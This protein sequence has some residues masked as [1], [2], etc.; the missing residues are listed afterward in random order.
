MSLLWE[1]ELNE[2]EQLR[3]TKST[4]RTCVD[5]SRFMPPEGGAVILMIMMMC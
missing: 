1:S 3:S 4:L 5:Q 2:P